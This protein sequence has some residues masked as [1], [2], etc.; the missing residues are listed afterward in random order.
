M[1]R[2]GDEAAFRPLWLP[3]VAPMALFLALT[4]AEGAVPRSVYP[5]LYGAKVVLVTS[6]LFF[7]RRA[8]QHEIRFEA[9]VLLSALL[10]GAA[11][12]AQWILLDKLVP[13]PH[14]GTR[15]ALDPFAAMPEPTLRVGFLAARF[16]GLVL[17]VPVMEELFWRSFLLRYVTDPDFTSLPLG[18]F[19]P[20]AFVIVAGLFGVSHPEWLV[21]V[22]CAGAY[23]LLLRHTRSLFACI[24]AHG[25]T[26][27]LLGVYVLVTGDWK[28]W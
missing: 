23:A 27:L 21:A 16:F 22:V 3:Y 2:G 14:L 24:V 13:Y 25:A 8:W 17:L 1:K 20:A 15:A 26:N 6:S 9:R 28:Y 19:S 18:S 11:V 4:M 12:F 7:F 5:W 10:V